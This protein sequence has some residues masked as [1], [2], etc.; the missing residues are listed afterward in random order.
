MEKI[1]EKLAVWLMFGS[2]RKA[3]SS[4]SRSGSM[5]LPI[6]SKQPIS[7]PPESSRM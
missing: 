5:A 4:P 6:D 1:V 2:N 7:S 3:K